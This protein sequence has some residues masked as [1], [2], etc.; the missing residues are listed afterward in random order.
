MQPFNTPIPPKAIPVARESLAISDAVHGQPWLT[1][2]NTGMYQSDDDGAMS[3]PYLNANVTEN[4]ELARQN[5]FQ[6]A[7][8]AA[9]QAAAGAMGAVRKAVTEQSTQ[10]FRAQELL[11]EKM[12][13]WLDEKGGGQGLMKFNALTGTDPQLAEL[14]NDLFTQQA[15][16]RREA[17]EL[18]AQ[19]AEEQYYRRA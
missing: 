4:Q 10:E 9:P 18:G 7:Q 14:R 12:A 3:K 8:T 13:F 2:P 16:A 15:M 6:N 17:P 1:P 5:E 11:N 19:R